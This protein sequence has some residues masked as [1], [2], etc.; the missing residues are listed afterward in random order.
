MHNEAGLRKEMGRAERRFFDVTRWVSFYRLQPHCAVGIFVAHQ[1]SSL[2]NKVG[3][4][5]ILSLSTTIVMKNW[6]IDIY[7]DDDT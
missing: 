4:I 7:D 5:M 1:P 6:H 2:I 3:I